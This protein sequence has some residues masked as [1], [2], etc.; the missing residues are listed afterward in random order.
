MLWTDKRWLVVTICHELLPVWRPV[1]DSVYWTTLIAK[2]HEEMT[3]R[4]F[5]VF[6]DE[7]K[8]CWCVWY[9]FNVKTKSK[10]RTWRKIE[11]VSKHCYGH[12]LWKLD[13]FYYLTYVCCR[14]I[15]HSGWL[16]LEHYCPV[17]STG[18]LWSCKNK[19]KSHCNKQLTNFEHSVTTGKSQTLA[20]LYW[21]CYGRY[22]KVLVWDFPLRPHSRLIMGY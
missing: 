2:H 20:L 15:V 8:H 22:G 3:H 17:I 13:E 5:E 16:I 4:D 1:M 6:G 14:Y 21:P 19:A 12:V 11:E 18:L 7:V 10:E 9:I